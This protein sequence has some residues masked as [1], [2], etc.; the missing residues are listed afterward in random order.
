MSVPTLDQNAQRHSVSTPIPASV[1]AQ[2]NQNVQRHSGSITGNACVNAEIGQTS[3]LTH[4][5]T[6]S[7]T[8]NVGAPKCS[9]ALET[10]DSTTIPASVNV[11]NHIQ[12]VNIRKFTTMVG[13]DVNAPVHDKNVNIHMFTITNVAHVNVQR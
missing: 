7:T 5:S 9:N 11:Q 10:S 1:S 2:L 4:K 3:A 6:M 8:V 13:V 12:N